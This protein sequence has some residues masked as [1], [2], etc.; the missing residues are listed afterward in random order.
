MV[1]KWPAVFLLYPLMPEGVREVSGVRKVSGLKKES[2]V[3]EVSGISLLLLLLSCF[4]QLDPDS[5][6]TP[7]SSATPWD[8]SVQKP[9]QLNQN[10]SLKINQIAQ[11]LSAKAP[12]RIKS[13]QKSDQDTELLCFQKS[14]SCKLKTGT[15]DTQT[16]EP[17]K[18]A[19]GVG[20]KASGGAHA[21]YSRGSCRSAP[22]DGGLA[23]ISSFKENGEI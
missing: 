10:V 7:L 14:W 4:S 21:P 23:G 1:H 20:T 11:G 17:V 18:W 22:A 12:A 3:R 19:R 5:G 16:M 9:R 15:E 13:N 2:G 8:Y 6:L